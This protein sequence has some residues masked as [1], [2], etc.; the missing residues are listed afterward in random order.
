MMNLF[1]KAGQQAQ[2]G[3]KAG[4]SKMVGLGNKVM[5]NK[6]PTPPPK[7]KASTRKKG[8]VTELLEV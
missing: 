4:A 2:A 7:P 1:S 6:G 8:E 3:V 5:N